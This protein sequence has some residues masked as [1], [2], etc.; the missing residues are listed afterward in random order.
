MTWISLGKTASVSLLGLSSVRLHKSGNDLKTAL[1][2]QLDTKDFPP[3]DVT[4]IQLLSC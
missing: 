4:E 3:S 2:P 1:K